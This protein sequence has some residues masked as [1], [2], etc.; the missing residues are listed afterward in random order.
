MV[1]PAH[2]GSSLAAA[3]RSLIN[4]RKRLRQMGRAA[5]LYAEGRSFESAFEEAWM[6]YEEQDIDSAPNHDLLAKA[7]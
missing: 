1:V 7:I 4:D 3:I 5:R 2:D 6:M